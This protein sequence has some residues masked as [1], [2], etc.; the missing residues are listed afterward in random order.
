MNVV[1]TILIDPVVSFQINGEAEAAA[2]SV[3]LIRMV[4]FVGLLLGQLRVSPCIWVRGQVSLSW[5]G[6]TCLHDPWSPVMFC[7]VVLSWYW[8]ATPLIFAVHDE[9][10]HFSL[11]CC[12]DFTQLSFSVW[13]SVK[14]LPSSS[15]SSE[16][17]CFSHIFYMAWL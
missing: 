9:I 5:P 16:L 3:F 1:V 10:I 4:L 17:G 12:L 11:L 7:D 14:F 15:L 6:V 2:V 13:G 8:T